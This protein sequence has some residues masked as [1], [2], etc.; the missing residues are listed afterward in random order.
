MVKKELRVSV[1][2]ISPISGEE[3]YYDVINMLEEIIAEATAVLEEL[4]NPQIKEIYINVWSS[5]ALIN[6]FVIER[7]DS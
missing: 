7:E 3:A 4:K 2:Q 5:T 1:L 6:E